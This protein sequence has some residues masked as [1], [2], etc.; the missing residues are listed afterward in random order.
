MYD[1]VQFLYFIFGIFENYLIG[2]FASTD[3]SVRNVSWSFLQ[4]YISVLYMA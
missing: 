1:A 3:Q 2:L 4:T